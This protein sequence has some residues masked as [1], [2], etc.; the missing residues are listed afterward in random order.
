MD[1]YTL[2]WKDGHREIVTG[3]SISDACMRAGYCNGAIAAL[4]FFV[5]D[6]CNDFIFVEG[7]WVNIRLATPVIC[8]VLEKPGVAESRV[9]YSNA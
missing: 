8:E 9:F 3:T 2:Y 6:D 7:E 1:R 5:C 4:D